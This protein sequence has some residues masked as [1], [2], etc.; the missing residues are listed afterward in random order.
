MLFGQKQITAEVLFD[1]VKI[2]LW[3][4]LKSR[5]KHSGHGLNS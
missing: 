3:W 4:W 5:K 1:M 2:I